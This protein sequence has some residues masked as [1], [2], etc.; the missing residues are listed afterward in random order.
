LPAERELAAR[1][2]VSRM[3]LHEA[4]Q[5]LSREGLL[6]A[7]RGKGGGTFV[8]IHEAPMP[9]PR[10][11]RMAKAMGEELLDALDFRFV[12]EP[13]AAELAAQRAD[14]NDIARLAK[15]LDELRALSGE[16][17]TE[18]RQADVRFHLA[19]AEISRCAT[20][21]KAVAEVQFRISDLLYA[22]AV[23]VAGSIR[24]G[25]RQHA[26]IFRAIVKRNSKRA[27]Q[28]MEEH[29][30]ATANLLIGLLG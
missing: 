1:L 26:E 27:R 17:Y 7:R 21:R 11:R 2:G 30:S 4:I 14:K 24:H 10:A 8:T 25:N 23:P 20:L 28:V 18:Y 3:T 29:V 6:E 22:V 15:L 5:A 16:N 19:I 12:V 9:N 13:A